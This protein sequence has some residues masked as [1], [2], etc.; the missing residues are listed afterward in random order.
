MTDFPTSVR[1]MNGVTTNAVV[2]GDTYTFTIEQGR[3]MMVDLF[4]SDEY[5]VVDGDL[6]DILRREHA[7][8]N[9][10]DED[11]G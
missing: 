11:E 2:Y 1:M 7:M 8:W 10:M 6:Y 9:E 5:T 4:C 3:E